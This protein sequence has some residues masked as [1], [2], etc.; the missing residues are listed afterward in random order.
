MARREHLDQL[1]NLR[2]FSACTNKELEQIARVTDEVSV[3]AGARIVSQGDVAREAF[4]VVEGT[5][6]VV[7]GNDAVAQLGPGRHFGELA[8]LDGGPRTA[9]VEAL[10][11]MR[12]LVISR[13]AFLGLLDEHPGIARRIMATM[14]SLIRDLE[15]PVGE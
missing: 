15:R 6:A 12:L 13:P 7:I 9:N 4:V 14:A 2:L 8:L 11:P 3:D 1:R 5:A 10:T